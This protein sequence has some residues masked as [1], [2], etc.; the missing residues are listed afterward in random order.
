MKKTISVSEAIK[1]CSTEKGSVT[2]AMASARV[3]LVRPSVW[4][5]IVCLANAPHRVVSAAVHIVGSTQVVAPFFSKAQTAN[6]SARI[7][8]RGTVPHVQDFLRAPWPDAV[9]RASATV[10]LP[11]SVLAMPALAHVDLVSARVRLSGPPTAL[12]SALSC[13]QGQCTSACI[14]LRGDAALAE[15]ACLTAASLAPAMPVS[16]RVSLS[17]DTPL[18]PQLAAAAAYEVSHIRLR[19]HSP[20]DQLA[21]ALAK[22][23]LASAKIA[24][25]QDKS[26]EP[27]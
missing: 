7:R 17:G 4:N 24:I 9:N 21:S 23:P 1:L 3:S 2:A 12:A 8:L 18:G 14:T 26:A 19:L 20:L 16:A 13:A 5:D 15:A 10:S 11:G 22:M 27:S 25:I 6:V